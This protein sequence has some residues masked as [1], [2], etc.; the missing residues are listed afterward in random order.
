MLATVSDPRSEQAKGLF[1]GNPAGV[2]YA[3]Q[4]QLA[5]RW[6]REI[7]EV[8]HRA[9]TRDYY[10]DLLMRVGGHE[11]A[12]EWVSGRIGE[13]G[14]RRKRM[15]KGSGSSSLRK[16]VLVGQGFRAYNE[17]VKEKVGESSV[18]TVR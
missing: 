15:T 18:S 6:S 7:E 4:L 17:M 11:K 2:L 16:R 12:K 1:R 3:A 8:A 10:Y 9:M 14:G 5:I 13:D